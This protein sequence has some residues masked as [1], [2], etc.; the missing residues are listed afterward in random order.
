MIIAIADATG[1]RLRELPLT[2]ARIKAAIGI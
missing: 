2:A 1:A